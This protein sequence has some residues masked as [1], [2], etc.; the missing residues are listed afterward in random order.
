MI[1]TPASLF[2]GAR[3]G[4]NLFLRILTEKVRKAD[5]LDLFGEFLFFVFPFLSD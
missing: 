4:V 1:S 3:W 2:K 5:F